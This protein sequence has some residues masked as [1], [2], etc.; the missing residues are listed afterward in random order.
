MTDVIFRNVDPAVL[1]ELAKLL[2]PVAGEVVTPEWTEEGAEVLLRDL[3]PAARGL[4]REVTAAGGR[5]DASRMRG[6]NGGNSLRGLTGPVKKAIARLAKAE[7]LPPGLPV[8]V[9]ADYDP[10]VRSYQ[11]TRAF[12]MPAALVPVFAAAIRRIDGSTA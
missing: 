3:G 6:T 2:Q 1:P 4:V 11:R 9:Y 12:V 8:P 10:S 7:K 5:I